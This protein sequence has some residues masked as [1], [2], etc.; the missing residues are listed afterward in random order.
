MNPGSHRPHK[1][2]QLRR[3]HL[4]DKGFTILETMLGLMIGLV[5]LSGVMA[6]FPPTLQTYRQIQ[7]HAHLNE[8]ERLLEDRLMQMISQAGYSGW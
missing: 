3:S 6:L 1:K 7:L 8:T 5:I 2:M 4:P